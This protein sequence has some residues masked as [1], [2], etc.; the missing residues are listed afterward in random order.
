MC[1]R[2]PPLFPPSDN[3]GRTLIEKI[4]RNNKWWYGWIHMSMGTVFLDDM[5]TWVSDLWVKQIALHNVGGEG[6][7]QLKD[8]LDLKD[9]TLPTKRDS[10][11][12]QPSDF[13]QTPGSF[14]LPSL[15]AHSTEWTCQPSLP[16]KAYVP[17][18]YN[19]LLSLSL[20]LKGKVTQL[21]LTLCNP[22]DCTVHGILQARILEG[23]AFRFS[24]G[25]S[26]LRD[27][28]EVFHIAGRFFTS[29]ATR[30]AQEYCSE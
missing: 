6:P 30:V 26:Q 22:M 1:Y 29:W 28:T 2:S 10:P 23:V 5:S 3:G 4:Q 25:S 11:V 15:P 17:I 12:K 20:S 14:R 27:Q 21:Y 13:I 8:Q 7:K 24:R 19:K 9:Q 18:P 16:P